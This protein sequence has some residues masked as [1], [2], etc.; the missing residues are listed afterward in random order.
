[1]TTYK[2]EEQ[3][4]ND[5]YYDEKAEEEAK[6]VLIERSIEEKHVVEKPD[7][8]M[9]QQVYEQVLQNLVHFLDTTNADELSF[10]YKME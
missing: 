4:D 1:M 10:M 8:E 5:D 3:H 9:I 6:R 2:Q 7:E